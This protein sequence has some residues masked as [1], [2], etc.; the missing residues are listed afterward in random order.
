MDFLAPYFT[1]ILKIN[2]KCAILIR[3][4]IDKLSKDGWNGG[5][6]SV[7]FHPPLKGECRC[8]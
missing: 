4:D 8:V 1:L 2:A 6:E 3:N 5:Y 7:Y